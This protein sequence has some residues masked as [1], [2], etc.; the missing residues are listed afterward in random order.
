VVFD[1]RDSCELIDI[2]DAFPRAFR[3]DH[4]Q[5]HL[6]ASHYV[7]RALVGPTLDQVHHEC[8]VIYRSQHDPD[9]A[10]FQDEDWITSTY[11]EDGRKIAALMHSEYHGDQHPG[12]CADMSD[13][14]RAQDC[15]WIAITYAQSQDGGKSFKEP[16]PPA[17]L[18]ASLPYP[19]DK[20]NKSGAEGYDS[21]TNI[22]KLGDYYYSILNVRN[23]YKA[24]P[25][26]PCLVRTGD[27]FDPSSWRGFD[28]KA[29]AI[30]FIDPYTER[31]AVPERH[32]CYPIVPGTI[33]SLAIDE[34]TGAILG[35]VYV[36][37]DRYGHGPGLYIMASRDLIHWS[38]ASLAASTTE[39][40]ASD[41]GANVSY[42][43][44][45]LLDPKSKDRN[46]STV[47]A[48]PCVYYVRLDD[49]HP[50]YRRV[51]LRRRIDIAVAQ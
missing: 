9:P 3:D 14:R 16:T 5:V 20:D 33:D 7:A 4:N 12:E 28:G 13:P 43:Y 30:N 38:A 40:L 41:Y 17:N 49:D 44:F 6:I 48:T 26:G 50:P 37:D 25:Y 35:I 22:L 51:L 29:F 8:A 39:L 1:T 34:R 15:A 10:H 45:S 2:P 24:Q 18:V 31:D 46:F 42:L 23:E 21:P 47:S 32:V 36:E 11:T 27:V 19:Y